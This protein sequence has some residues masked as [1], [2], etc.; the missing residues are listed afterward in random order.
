MYVPLNIA[1]ICADCDAIFDAKT[2]EVCP[3]CGSRQHTKLDKLLLPV[4][5]VDVEILAVRTEKRPTTPTFS[6]AGA[7]CCQ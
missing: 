3:V 7:K 2:H 4:D 5:G 1:F 6:E